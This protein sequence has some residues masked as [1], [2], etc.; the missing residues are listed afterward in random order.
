MDSLEKTVKDIKTMKTRGAT[1]TAIVAL[2]VLKEISKKKGF[3]REFNDA[4]KR[5]ENAR[6]TA[7]VIHNAIEM[8]KKKKTVESIT[9]L[10]GYLETVGRTI[11]VRNHKLIKN[12]SIVLT[13]CHSTEVVWLLRTARENGR[14]F[15][16]MV[17]ETRPVYQ[18]I[19][20]AK[21]LTENYIEVVYIIDD[22]F[23][24][25]KDEIDMM[26]VG[27]DSIR[28]GGITNKIGT[29]PMA[30][31]AKENNIPVYFVGS[32]IKL[33]K[34]EKFIIEERSSKEI[35]E[36]EKIKKCKIRNPSFDKTPLKYVTGVVTEK[37]VLK[38][39]QILRM[40]K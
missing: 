30:V 31:F 16:V 39:K 5:L 29:Y 9:D 20:T 28:S 25:Y 18:G 40:L 14:K 17:T 6:P 27:C 11:G 19:T 26:I 3:G 2:K 22:A 13:H 12:N 23:G 35:I 38:P 34:R 37:G 1:P 21:E 8:V 32:L 15:K 10:I 4:C 36:P 7:V 24:L 33:D